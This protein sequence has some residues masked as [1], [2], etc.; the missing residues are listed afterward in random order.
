MCGGSRGSL[1]LLILAILC[2]AA[3]IGDGFRILCVFPLTGKSHFIMGESLMRGLAERGHQVD[4][5]SHF[6][7]KKPPPNYRDYSLAGTLPLMVN[8]LTY[9]FLST[10]M[11]QGH[12][13]SRMMS[14]SG[15]NI[16]EMLKL[17][18]FQRL[19]KNPPKNPPYD[20]VITELFVSNCYL[21]FG[22]H[23]DLPLV[24]LVSTSML[25]WLHDPLGNPHNPAVDTS[26]LSEYYRPATFIE[27]FGNFLTSIYIKYSFNYYVRSQ[28]AYVKKYFGPGLPNVVEMQ[29]DIDLV[30]VNYHHALSGIRVH[31]PAIVPVGGLHIVDT[32]ET[33]PPSVQRFL[34]RSEHGFVYV[35][36]GSMV[37]LE[38][39]PKHVLDVFYGAFAKIA[40]IR[41]LMKIVEPEE[42]PPGLPSNVITRSWLPQIAVLKHKNIKA[43]V[44]HGGVMSTQES[45]YFGVPMVGIPL[46][47]DQPFN[48]V[49]YVQKNLAVKLNWQ[50]MSATDLAKAIK[51]VIENPIYK[52]STNKVSK[53]FRDVPMSPK[54]T[55][56]F[57]VEFIAR[58]GKRTL[59]HP[60][61]DMPWWQASLLDIY[62]FLIFLI[63]PVIYALKR[64]FTLTLSKLIL[65]CQSNRVKVK[66]N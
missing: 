15:D 1:R 51:M 44:T 33:L 53:L 34:D 42:L 6:P 59:R 27:R 3:R 36:F 25:D 49:A 32:N 12:S 41:V 5:Y 46:F 4:V 66:R 24:G 38:T 16:C 47:G 43:F 8:N 60:L 37:R 54:N 2:F 57:W 50:N 20:L 29:K 21:A 48:V 28:D 58:H 7:L 13:M 55:S 26:I 17:P 40:P 10:I 65:Q 9:Q 64:I 61:V 62:A 45:I 56:V 19:I 35:S 63:L 18:I 23:L 14:T 39:F 22:R 11:V 52:E 30:L 31:T